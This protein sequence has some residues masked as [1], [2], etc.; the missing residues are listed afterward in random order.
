MDTANVL[1]LV[2][3]LGLLGLILATWLAVRWRRR[4]R[5]RLRLAEREAHERAEALLST[6]L[7]G[8][9]YAQLDEHG[10]LEVASPSQPNRRY[11]VPRRPGRVCVIDS[12][13]EVASLC[14]APVEWMPPGDILL[15]HKLMIEGDEQ[16]Y[17]RR[18]NHYLLRVPVRAPSPV[19]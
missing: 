3:L 4:W 13:V 18:A 6:M 16:E 19:R 1:S 17:L 5:R 11:R 7:T 15:T 8:E 12:G 10:Y 9:E 2:T 14:V